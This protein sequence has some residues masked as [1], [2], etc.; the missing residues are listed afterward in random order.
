[1]DFG[2][3]I[4]S[5]LPGTQEKEWL[6]TNGIGGYASGTGTQILDWLLAVTMGLLMAALQPPLGRTLLLVTKLD[7]TAEYD[8]VQ[9]KNGH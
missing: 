3:D 2:R 6:V 7:E 8:G 4:C 9:A 5:A 1:M